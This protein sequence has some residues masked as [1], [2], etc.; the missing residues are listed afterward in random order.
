MD[1]EVVRWRKP[2]LKMTKIWRGEKV[3]WLVK[4]LKSIRPLGGEI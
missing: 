3:L 2:H 4:G 1:G